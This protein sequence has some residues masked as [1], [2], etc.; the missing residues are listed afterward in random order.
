[1]GHLLATGLLCALGVLYFTSVVTRLMSGW[2]RLLGELA[3]VAAGAWLAAYLTD[4][5]AAVAEPGIAMLLIAAHEWVVASADQ[6]KTVVISRHT[7]RRLP[8]I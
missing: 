3:L 4:W 8:P 5:R 1:M 6:A 2:P 7:G